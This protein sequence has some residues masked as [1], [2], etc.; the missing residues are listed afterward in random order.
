MVEDLL[1]GEHIVKSWVRAVLDDFKVY[2]H[3]PVNTGY[4]S[5]G[6][7]FHCVVGYKNL[8]LAFFIETKKYGEDTTDRQD[9]FI[10][11]RQAEQNAITFVIDRKAG[12]EKLRK[13]LEGLQH[14][15]RNRARKAGEGTV[16]KRKG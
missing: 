7:D 6:L 13:W 5:A 9:T 3:M 11:D 1:V 8:A 4:G 10:K 14:A 2:Y 15:D 12:V 16:D